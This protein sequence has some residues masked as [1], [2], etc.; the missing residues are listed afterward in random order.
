MGRQLPDLFDGCYDGEHRKL[1]APEQFT[2][3]FC[4]VC[5]NVGCR[6]SKG[7]GTR[8]NKRMMT[9]EDRLLNNPDFAPENTAMVMGLP[10]FKNMIQ[11]ALR[12]EIS[13]QRNDWEPVSDADVGRAAAEMMGVLPPSG[14]QKEPD[15]TPDPTP[16]PHPEPEAAGDAPAEISGQ[17]NSTL[18][19]PLTEPPVEGTWR[20]RGDSLDSKGKPRTYTV[21]L[22]ESGEWG[23]NCPSRENPCKHSRYIQARLTPEK[24]SDPV[25]D[26]VRPTP[27]PRRTPLPSAMNTS[28]PQGGIMVGGGQPPAPTPP[29]DPWAVPEGPKIRKIEVG[30]KVTFGSGTKKK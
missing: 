1:M 6:N 10:D 5:M 2:Q 12:I 22:Y 13:T 29:A 3:M 19:T 9:Q 14:F 26:P 18:D 16:Q 17:A 8:W 27:A 15:P 28:Q 24:K 21:T 11:D 20:V 7:A 30:G 4:S 23:C 25:P